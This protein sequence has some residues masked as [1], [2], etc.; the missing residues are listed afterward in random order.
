MFDTSKPLYIVKDQWPGVDSWILLDHWR[1]YTGQEAM[2]IKPGDLCLVSSP[3]SPT[4]SDLYCTLPSTES[5]SSTVLPSDAHDDLRPV[6]NVITELFQTELAALSLPLRKQLATCAINDVR[7]LYLAHDK[8]MFGIIQEELDDLVNTQ[9]VLTSQEADL[10]RTSLAVTYNP[11]S[12]RMRYLLAE[13][14]KDATGKDSYL[15]KA[16][17]GGMGQGLAFGNSMTN[18]EWCERLAK[19]VEE[20]QT[21]ESAT[22]CVQKVVVQKWYDL[23]LRD[24]VSRD[25]L[26]WIAT[27]IA[28]AGEYVG[29]GAWRSAREVSWSV[30]TD[31]GIVAFTITSA[32]E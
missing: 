22:H 9:K 3:D 20:E 30:M 13:C 2:F 24:G 12:Q 7:S 19:L 28:M 31:L 17:R 15:L 8:R 21:I 32:K 5:E 4:G 14:R 10:L 29:N 1:K 23:V 25:R 16:V 27:Y 11:G 6:H 18:E 26:H